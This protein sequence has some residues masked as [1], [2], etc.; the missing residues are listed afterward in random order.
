MLFESVRFFGLAVCPLTTAVVSVALGMAAHHTGL[1]HSFR[2]L[3]SCEIIFMGIVI[4]TAVPKPAN[5]SCTLVTLYVL[6]ELVWVLRVG[7]FPHYA[8][9]KLLNSSGVGCQPS[10]CTCEQC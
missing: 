1:M 8:F 10:L 2:R 7:C 4:H 9:S 3:A 6:F 5:N